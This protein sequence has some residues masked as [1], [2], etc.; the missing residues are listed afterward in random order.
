MKML[1]AAMLLELF[2]M[3]SWFSQWGLAAGNGV[4]VDLGTVWAGIP[5]TANGNQYKSGGTTPGSGTW[6]RV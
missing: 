5:H 2:G 3:S 1:L 4:F 6:L